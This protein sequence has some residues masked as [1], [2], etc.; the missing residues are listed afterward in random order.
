MYSLL[1]IPG[2]MH[3]LPPSLPPSSH[4]NSREDLDGGILSGGMYGQVTVHP[5]VT[6]APT[7]LLQSEPG[8]HLILRAGVC[9]GS[10]AILHAHGGILEIESGVSLGAAVLLVGSGK[11]GA[12]ACVGSMVTI[13]NPAIASGDVI[14]AGTLLG[15]SSRS[16]ELLVNFVPNSQPHS[17]TQNGTVPH[18][19][20]DALTLDLQQGRNAQIVPGKAAL[21]ELLT[22]LFPHR[23]DFEQP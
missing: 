20:V 15:D 3:L 17:P 22:A 4:D 1:D 7:A 6:I 23:Q 10:G 12:N 14:T 21:N 8:S 5:S 18:G 2:L 9:I 13:M 19:K 16:P 11:I